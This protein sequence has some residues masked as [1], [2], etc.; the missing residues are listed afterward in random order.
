MSLAGVG[1][2]KHRRDTAAAGVRIAAGWKGKGNRHRLK[3]RSLTL[4]SRDAIRYTCASSAAK[5][6]R[7]P[8][9]RW[10]RAFEFAPVFKQVLGIAH[11]SRSIEDT[12]FY[13]SSKG[14][15]E[16]LVQCLSERA[17][18]RVPGNSKAS[19]SRFH[20]D[21]SAV[22]GPLQSDGVLPIAVGVSSLPP[23]QQNRRS[24]TINYVAGWH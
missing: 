2:T 5:P 12:C 7:L 1:R 21:Q 8:D 16:A 17:A 3:R 19:L 24:S 4:L 14:P 10:R 13:I 11:A 9:E 22:S 18:S 6:S 20:S 23:W 15:F